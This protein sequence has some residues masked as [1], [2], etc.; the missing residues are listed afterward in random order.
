MNSSG[1]ADKIVSADHGNTVGEPDQS[2]PTSR[3]ATASAPSRGETSSIP[4]TP[5]Q[6]KSIQFGVGGLLIFTTGLCILLAVLKGLGVSYLHLLFGFASTIAFSLLVILLLEAHKH[7]ATR[8]LAHQRSSETVRNPYA[9]P[10]VPALPARSRSNVS[11]RVDPRGVNF[12]DPEG[13]E[14]VSQQRPPEETP[15]DESEVFSAHLADGDPPGDGNPPGDEPPPP[16][17]AAGD[18]SP[19]EADSGGS[20]AGRDADDENR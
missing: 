20:A 13:I 16:A 6:G 15:N 12:I 4:Q 1:E 14:F 18:G 7:F 3:H 19:G 11:T 5:P 9:A 17:S 2:T 8:Q 10:D